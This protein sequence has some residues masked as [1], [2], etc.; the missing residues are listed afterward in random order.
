MPVHKLSGFST[1]A[2]ERFEKAAQE[3]SWESDQGSAQEVARA[4]AEYELAK[5]ALL[6][7]LLFLEKQVKKYKGFCA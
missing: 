7:R 2:V 6:D 4:K 3:H 1:A 5:Q